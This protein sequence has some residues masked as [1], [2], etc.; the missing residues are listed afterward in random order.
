VTFSSRILIWPVQV[1]ISSLKR[2]VIIS[3]LIRGIRYNCTNIC[4]PSHSYHRMC[5]PDEGAN[6]MNIYLVER[7]NASESWKYPSRGSKKV[8][9]ELKNWILIC[10]DGRL[11]RQRTK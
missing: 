10:L 11:L 4:E 9:I 1:Y 5:D 6:T 3:I 7:M 2:W 8:S